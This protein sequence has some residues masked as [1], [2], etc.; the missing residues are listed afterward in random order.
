[1]KI[2]THSY[3]NNFVSKICAVLLAVVATKI[4]WSAV[5][6]DRSLLISAIPTISILLLAAGVFIRSRLAQRALVVFLL[7]A[8]V[9]LPIGVFNPFTAGDY[10][11]A[12]KQ[13]P[14]INETLIWLVPVE[15]LLI[16]IIYFLDPR[17]SVSNG[18]QH[19]NQMLKRTE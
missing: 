12:G 16:A 8:A 4:L 9:V 1:M 14:T 17:K 3:L 11:V 19:P 10:L 15:A 18:E 2:E 5:S 6:N 7:I 13:P